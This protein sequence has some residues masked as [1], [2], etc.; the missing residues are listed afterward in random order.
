MLHYV[1]TTVVPKLERAADTASLYVNT[2]M[3]TDLIEKPFRVRRPRDSGEFD[4]TDLVRQCALSMDRAY[5]GT[6][7]L[8]E[9]S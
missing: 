9:R 8:C 1:S 7:F 2:C 4:E 3:C 5:V 6:L